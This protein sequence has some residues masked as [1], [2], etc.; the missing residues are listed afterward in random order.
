MGLGLQ[1]SFEY[2]NSSGELTKVILPYGAWLRWQYRDFVF[3]DG[4]TLR[5]VQNRYLGT[6]PGGSETAYAFSRDENDSGHYIHTA[7]FLDGPSG[8]GQKAWF[9]VSAT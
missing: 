6:L 2:N 8:N 4:R 7:A 1:H 5:E 9:F 3:T